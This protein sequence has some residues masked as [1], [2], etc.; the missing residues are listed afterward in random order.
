M[1]CS[2]LC[3]HLLYS[4]FEQSDTGSRVILESYFLATFS[5]P[6]SHCV[7]LVW[8]LIIN[9][10]VHM[11][12]PPTHMNTSKYSCFRYESWISW[13]FIFYVLG[14]VPPAVCL[15]AFQSF[16]Y[17][18][19]DFVK[20][21]KFKFR[22][23]IFC[24]LHATALWIC[25]LTTQYFMVD[26]FLLFS[27]NLILASKVVHLLANP[28]LFCLAA[29]ICLICCL[30]FLLPALYCPLSVFWLLSSHPSCSWRIK[31]FIFC[32][33]WK[34]GYQQ[35]SVSFRPQWMW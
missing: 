2:L 25:S 13:F 1:L 28:S 9:G 26:S 21:F 27:N 15:R 34:V 30:P 32:I 18:I 24:V 29:D 20:F 16:S 4:I 19:I 7:I 3:S 11:S 12:C 22:G 14:W 31:P 5:I 33:T 23:S 35:Y 8:Y 6:P 10:S 17:F